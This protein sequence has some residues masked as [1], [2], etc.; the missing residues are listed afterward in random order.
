MWGPYVSHPSSSSPFSLSPL[1]PF[2]RW[3]AAAGKLGL[4]DLASAGGGGG[5]ELMRE[6][7]A[8][9]SPTPGPPGRSSLRSPSKGAHQAGRC[10]TAASPPPPRP[11]AA[12]PSI[13]YRWLYVV[14]GSSLPLPTMPARMRAQM[15]EIAPPPPDSGLP[16]AAMAMAAPRADSIFSTKPL[17]QYGH[18]S[19]AR[20][21]PPSSPPLLP[22]S[23]PPPPMQQLGFLS[24]VATKDSINREIKTQCKIFFFFS[25]LLFSFAFHHQK[26]LRSP[27]PR[28]GSINKKQKPLRSTCGAQFCFV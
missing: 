4:H 28:T 11:S 18:S 9:P 15:E 12:H 24:W 17:L 25:F 19:T 21:R 14:D 6:R 27:N 2:G 7:M 26:A 3:R 23:S 1:L 22:I 8:A 16:P 10:R 5:L 13:F 20:R